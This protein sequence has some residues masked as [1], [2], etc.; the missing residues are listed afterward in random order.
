MRRLV[1]LPLFALLLPLA[2]P[3]GAQIVGRRDYGPVAASDPFIGDG[4]LPGPGI[5]RDLRDI[6]HR[7][8]RARDSGLLSRREARQFRREARRI[9]SAAGVYGRDGISAS[10]HRELEA[11]AFALRSQLDRPGR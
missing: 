6:N 11:R 9:G 3:A 10:E 1:L 5:W 4:R 8:D 2:A 7:I